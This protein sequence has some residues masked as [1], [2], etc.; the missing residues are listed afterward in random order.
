MPQRPLDS[1]R[2]DQ[3][4]KPPETIT[5]AVFDPT[6][7]GIW[8]LE[9]K[10][11][12]VSIYR[13]GNR[14]N[15]IGGIGFERGSIKRLADIGIGDDGTLL[16]LD[17]MD[18]R[19]K[20]FSA[21]GAYLSEIA[22]DWIA[23]PE[24]VCQSSDQTLYIYDSSGAEIVC[25]SALDNTEQFR[26]GKF[27]L[28]L[29]TSLSCSRD[30]V[31]AYSSVTGKT[32]IFS[33]L[34]QLIRELDGFWTSDNFRNLLALNSRPD[35]SYQL[36]TVNPEA[37]SDLPVLSATQPQNMVLLGSYL[38]VSEADKVLIYRLEYRVNP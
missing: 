20:R 26:F 6:S 5:K 22:L 11:K 14:L 17:S 28:R 25:V 32:L 37:G 15:S 29:P 3:E 2:L 38:C 8:V 21:D 36:V 18:R 35:G 7:S 34:G 12:Q 33:S 31:T 9:A 13:N 16:I 1:M 27:Q 30:Y 19:L 4:F 10:S 23:G 24:L